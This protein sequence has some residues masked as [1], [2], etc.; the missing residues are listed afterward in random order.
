MNVVLDKPH[1]TEP[2]PVACEVCLAEIPGSV[3]CNAEGP[4]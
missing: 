1:P 2:E 3:A 4:D